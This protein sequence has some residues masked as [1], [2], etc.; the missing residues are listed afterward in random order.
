MIGGQAQYTKLFTRLHGVNGLPLRQSLKR[1]GT[2]LAVE[3][4]KS[5]PPRNQKQ[6]ENAI[7][8]DLNRLFM[9]V[10]ES[11]SDKVF[12]A[13]EDTNNINLWFSMPGGRKLNVQ[14]K[15]LDTTG[16]GMKGY[17]YSQRG[18]VRRVPSK[19]MRWGHYSGKGGVTSRAEFV[20][21]GDAY[22]SYLERTL[23]K[24][25][26][27]R[28]GWMPAFSKLSPGS[29]IKEAP[30]KW[31]TRH[32]ASARGALQDDTKQILHPSITLISRSPGI[33]SVV[34]DG[35]SMR[36]IIEWALRR[37]CL[38]MRKNISYIMK[39]KRIT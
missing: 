6:G 20:V 16:D 15:H 33:A 21:G 3:L 9:R 12:D 39:G 29:N 22:K 31:V 11:F 35:K 23:A 10:G 19:R 27:M 4:I 17:H 28:S 32:A 25:G 34:Q 24:V 13:A 1:E 18:G 38:A 37:R 30:P 2:M 8:R 36:N 7:R 14:W 26:R 5:T